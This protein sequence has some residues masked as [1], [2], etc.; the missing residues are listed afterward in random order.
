MNKKYVKLFLVMMIA[1][2]ASISSA[3]AKQFKKIEDLGTYISDW[4]TT[5]SESDAKYNKDSLDNVIVIGTH[6]FT[7]FYDFES[8]KVIQDASRSIDDELPS[9]YYQFTM[10][11]ETDDN[12]NITSQTWDFENPGDANKTNIDISKLSFLNIKYIDE[13]PIYD[14]K[15]NPTA[16]MNEFV[17]TLTNYEEQLEKSSADYYHVKMNGNNIDIILEND[18]R[19][20]ANTLATDFKTD[21]S[22]DYS[23]DDLFISALETAY[24]DSEENYQNVV[25]KYG[26]TEILNTTLTSIFEALGKDKSSVDGYSNYI[27]KLKSALGISSDIEL[28]AGKSLSITFN[29][30]TEDKD[31][32]DLDIFVDGTNTFTINF[33]K[34]AEAN[35][36]FA[37]VDLENIIDVVCDGEDSA[38]TLVMN[39]IDPTQPLLNFNRF[40]EMVKKALNSTEV[41]KVVL[42]LTKDNET[43]KYEFVSK[44][45]TSLTSQ[46]TEIFNKV[47]GGKSSLTINDLAELNGSTITFDFDTTKVKDKYNENSTSETYTFNIDEYVDTDSIVDN[48][49]N[50]MNTSK[51]SETTVTN[52]NEYYHLDRIGDKL[53]LDAKMVMSNS[54][55]FF[56]FETVTDGLEQ[57]IYGSQS[58]S[59]INSTSN[60]SIDSI[61]IIDNTKQKE[62]TLMSSTETAQ[63]LTLRKILSEI[64]DVNDITSSNVMPTELRKLDISIKFVIKDTNKL[65]PGIVATDTGA[66]SATYDITFNVDGFEFNEM[67]N[68]MFNTESAYF[69]NVTPTAVKN[70]YDIKLDLNS[71][72]TSLEDAKLFDKLEWYAGLFST[73]KVTVGNSTE[74]LD[75]T[76]LSTAKAKIASML[77]LSDS[78][79]ISALKGKAIT[80]EFTVADDVNNYTVNTSDWT[81]NTGKKSE[82]YTVKV[83]F[84]Y[85]AQDVAANGSISTALNDDKLDVLNLAEDAQYSGGLTISNNNNIEINGNG[86]TINGDVTVSANNVVI[87]DLNITGKLDVTG[88]NLVINGTTKANGELENTIKGSI[89]VEGTSSVSIDSM[90]IEGTKDA[91]VNR[92][93]IDAMG[94]GTLTLTNSEIK[95]IND[96]TGVTANGN[97]YSLLHLNGNSV[98]TDNTFDISGVKNP[99]EYNVNANSSTSAT[100]VIIYHNEFIGNNYIAS[101]AH[102]IISF[103]GA[104]NN[105]TITIDHNHF[106]YANWAV[107]VSDYNN[108]KVTYIITNNIVDH[109]TS[110]DNDERNDAAFMGLQTSTSHSSLTNITIKHDNNKIDGQDYLV[111]KIYEHKEVDAAKGTP[112]VVTR[113]GSTDSN[114]VAAQ[115]IGFEKYTTKVT[116]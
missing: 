60:T 51:V 61:I 29:V 67:M 68:Q 27:Q 47:Y 99:I 73:I 58:Y 98:I 14:S 7:N 93:V 114:S 11:I 24:E 104:A 20:E 111:D 100:N 31:Q 59:V 25:I 34:Y 96:G 21:N 63:K 89:K 82:T 105:A 74:T 46:F 19:D 69:T 62:Y 116:E 108:S 17:K 16:S 77:E 56:R 33:Y 10:K 75:L 94:T 26:N 50:M 109:I 90:K 97:V 72:G 78:D 57:I 42:N 41:N 39:L 103:Y 91:L 18:K 83:N 65:M 36:Y 55:K 110:D 79:N 4:V 12:G 49:A 85:K 106:A 40:S 66:K 76:N 88:N 115:G 52:A 84:T 3:S 35:D 48:I 86:A 92:S 107:R 2:F 80:F 1:F 37:N 45:T 112:L 71:V 8:I 38:C 32:N 101:D 70:A 22:E 5:Q 15:V 81:A 64:L 30:K 44:D 28:S 6:V 43:Y 113:D 23:L 87:N 95:Y 53:T 9:Y 102:N 13:K 54:G